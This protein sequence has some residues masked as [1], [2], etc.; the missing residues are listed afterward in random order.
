M[1]S[2]M[3]R[4]NINHIHF[5][6]QTIPSQ[7]PASPQETH[8]SAFSQRNTVLQ[9]FPS[10]NMWTLLLAVAILA[11]CCCEPLPDANKEFDRLLLLAAS[12]NLTPSA[13]LPDYAPYTKQ[14]LLDKYLQNPGKL[15]KFLAYFV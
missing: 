5:Q 6:A 7:S 2:N 15:M 14:T 1:C 11:N 10:S 4:S 12:G 8:T 9:H 13:N 3:I